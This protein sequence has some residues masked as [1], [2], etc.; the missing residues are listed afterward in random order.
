[1][2][3]MALGS[4]YLLRINGAWVALEGVAPGVARAADRPRSS[5]VTMGGTRHTQQARRAPRS[6]SWNLPYATAEG[7]RLLA[8]AVE[9]ADVWLLDTVAS[10][11]NM[12]A[13]W[14]TQ[15][16]TGTA[17]L[18]DGVP[19]LPLASGAA[20]S[21]VVRPGVL[22][23]VSCW[24]A[25]ASGASLL[26]ITYPGG[27]TALAAPAGTGLRRAEVSFT[28]NASGALA[29]TVTT[30]AAAAGTTAL[31]VVEGASQPRWLAGQRTPCRVSVADPEYTL[32]LIRRGIGYGEASV[33]LEEVG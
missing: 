29:T 1:M 7:L 23:R 5:M 13:P 24:T 21:T 17:L 28:P 33:T 20:T 2:T 15:G 10:A 25:A 19:L 22:L 27:S 26:T 3:V 6:W 16:A 12:L 11:S 31:Q 4:P 8:T 18:A 32:S 30:A 14:E 9:A